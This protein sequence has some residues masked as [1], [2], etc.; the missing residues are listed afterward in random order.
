MRQRALEQPG[1]A[2]GRA[3]LLG[4]PSTKVTPISAAGEAQVLH[5][6]LTQRPVYLPYDSYDAIGQ[7]SPTTW[8]R[9]A[10]GTT[11]HREE[12]EGCGRMRIRPSPAC[13]SLREERED[14]AVIPA[15]SRA[16]AEKREG[17]KP[18]SSRSSRRRSLQRPDESST[19]PTSSRSS[20]LTGP[21]PGLHTCS[22]RSSS[23]PL[24]PS[25]ASPT[26]GSTS[27]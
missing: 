3:C 17:L 26:R 15:R 25:S 16:H 20:R 10:V 18:T 23:I 14:N 8:R 21:A 13:M 9:P 11:R 12:R 6:H 1:P 4:N 2:M 22:G 19:L 24:A 5:G 27:T 7:I